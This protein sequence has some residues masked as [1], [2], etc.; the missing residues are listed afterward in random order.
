MS[1]IISFRGKLADGIQERISLSTIRGE[2]GYRI[3]K[4]EAMPEKPG[5][6]TGEHVCQIFSSERSAA[7]VTGTDDVDFS[8]TE[9][10][11]VLFI[12]NSTS[13]G[14]YPPAFTVVFDNRT[15][16]Q[17]IFITHVDSGGSAECNYHIEVEQRDLALDE[18][19]VATLKDIRNT[20][21]Q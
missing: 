8:N 2:V 7:E 19:T 17:D 13:G 4:F 5:R 12:N 3:V 11:G 21:T 1:K 16:N 14:S 6:L 10:L 18:S 9:L 15:F 20:G